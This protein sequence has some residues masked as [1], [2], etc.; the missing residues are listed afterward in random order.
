MQSLVDVVG[1]LRAIEAAGIRVGQFD[2]FVVGDAAGVEGE[3]GE[4]EG[5]REGSHLR[6]DYSYRYLDKC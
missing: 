1:A 6:Y 3:E 4:Q 2:E 5:D